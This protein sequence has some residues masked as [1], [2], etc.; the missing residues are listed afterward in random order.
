M[1]AALDE[2]ISRHV[3]VKAVLA[4]GV[5]ALWATAGAVAARCPEGREDAA[6]GIVLMLEPGVFLTERLGADGMVE[7]LQWME[8]STER[9]GF[10]AVHGILPVHV[11]FRESDAADAFYT[12]LEITWEDAAMPEPVP[13]LVWQGVGARVFRTAGVP[14]TAPGTIRYEMR[15]TGEGEVVIGTCRHASLLVETRMEESDARFVTEEVLDYLPALGIALVRRV[16]TVPEGEAPG[17]W[18]DWPGALAM[19]VVEE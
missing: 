13:G 1:L 2:V 12:G 9:T 8:G 11:I 17:E 3:G 7:S 4:C 10:A 18:H 14:D 6:R 15:V 19:A 5:V 16:R